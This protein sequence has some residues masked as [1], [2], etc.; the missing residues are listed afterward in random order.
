MRWLRLCGL[1]RAVC[2]FAGHA[3][4]FEGAVIVRKTEDRI[5]LFCRAYIID[6]NGTNAAIAAGYSKKSAHVSSTRLLKNAKVKAR[7]AE[8]Q[9]KQTD[10]LDITAERVLREIALLAYSNMDDYVRIEDGKR[11]LDTSIPTRDQ[12]AAVVE[13]TED[14]TGGSGDGERRAVIRTRFKLADKGLNLERLGRHLKLFTDKIEHS[15]L[16]T[17]A[18][19]IAASRARIANRK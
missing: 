3:L 13:I 12:M 2:V 11:V 14:S 4:A 9:K 1:S 8:L 10:K 17:L 5:E 15:G 18:D 19:K 16:E 6:F 7:L